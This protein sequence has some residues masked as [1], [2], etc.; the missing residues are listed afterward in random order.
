MDKKRFIWKSGD[1]VVKK[2]KNPKGEKNNVK[3]NKRTNN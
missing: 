1:V 3:S 2:K